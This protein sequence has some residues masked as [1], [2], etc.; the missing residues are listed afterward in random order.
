MVDVGFSPCF[1]GAGAHP[2]SVLKT[3]DSASCPWVRIPPPPLRPHASELVSMRLTL[4][5]QRFPPPSRA[6]SL[7][8]S[9]R[10]QASDRVWKRP[11]RWANSGQSVRLLVG[12][13]PRFFP[14]LP[15]GLR[16]P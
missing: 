10:P 5:F 1:S 8:P 3:V 12:L 14:R 7:N 6:E 9:S 16:C 2:A 13:P 11:L 4:F 15:V